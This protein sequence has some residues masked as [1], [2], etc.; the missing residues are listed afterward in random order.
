MPSH[1]QQSVPFFHDTVRLLSCESPARN[2]RRELLSCSVQE[3]AGDAKKRSRTIAMAR[4]IV[5][6]LLLYLLHGNWSGS[7]V[8]C[9]Q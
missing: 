1:L 7:M 5:G 3:L 8:F 2:W 4:E 9:P 6:N